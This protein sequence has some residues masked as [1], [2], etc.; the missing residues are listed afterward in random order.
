VASARILLEI[1]NVIA[2][3]D[4]PE[5]LAGKVSRSNDHF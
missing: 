5:R 4:T 3:L 1:S 2:N